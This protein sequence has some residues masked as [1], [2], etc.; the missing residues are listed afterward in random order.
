MGYY[1]SFKAKKSP[2]TTYFAEVALKVSKKLL[3]AADRLLVGKCAEL[4]NAICKLL[5]NC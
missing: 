1:V 5:I 4:E 2:G 3:K